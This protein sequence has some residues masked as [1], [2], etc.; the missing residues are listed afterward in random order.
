[1]IGISAD[2]VESHQSFARHHRLP[3]QLLSDSDGSVRALYG[4]RSTLGLIPG[5][6]TF[7]IDR[8]GIVRHVFRSQ[9]NATKHVKES[10]EVLRR[11]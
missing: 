9:M 5:R 1:V 2:S 11:I 6:E 3:M 7:V 10:L 4:V 8:Q